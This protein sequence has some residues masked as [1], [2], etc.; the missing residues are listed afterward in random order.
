MKQKS[1]Y[2]I[3]IVLLL[4]FNV[5]LIVK[6]KKVKPVVVE[7]KSTHAKDFYHNKF[8]AEKQ[9]ENLGIDGKLKLV[10]LKGDTVLAKNVWNKNQ[11]IFRYSALN[12]R[13]C[14]DTEY[15]H[16][17]KLA[18]LIDDE[19]SV[20]AYYNK[21][22]ELIVDQR[23]AQEKG[24]GNISFYLLPEDHLNIPMDNNNIPYY[25]QLSPTLTITNFF[26]PEKTLPQ[27]SEHYL[28]YAL[29]NM[30]K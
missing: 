8:L 21:P 14:I 5:F 1:I 17:A 2:T 25:F 23:L 11:I 15:Q 28:K 22:R 19:I 26:I 9:N 12:C 18:H 7:D 27:L 30:E 4:I 6:S 16:L 10:T 13:V 20:L 3:L 29:Q 24:L